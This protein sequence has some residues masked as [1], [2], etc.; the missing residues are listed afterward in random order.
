M[1]RIGDYAESIA[2]LLPLKP[3]VIL[4]DE[5]SSALD[6]RGT[7]AV[8]EL[9]TG[10]RNDY[11]IIIVTHNMAKARRVSDECVFMLLGEM[12]EHARTA[13]IPLPPKESKTIDYIEGR[14]G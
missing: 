2:R 14:Y 10:P 7:N 6:T 11:T 5:P 9:I 8:E 13:Q 3:R 12:I 1:E 4:M